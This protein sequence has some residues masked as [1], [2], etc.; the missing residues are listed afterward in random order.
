MPALIQ[1]HPLTL[2]IMASSLA[3]TDTPADTPWSSVQHD[4]IN[5]SSNPRHV[6]ASLSP[7]SAYLF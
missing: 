2:T 7:S 3:P 6:M 1:S 5:K 4:Y